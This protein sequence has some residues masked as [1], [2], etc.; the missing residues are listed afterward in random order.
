MPI[1]DQRKLPRRNNFPGVLPSA[2]L[3]KQFRNA[4]PRDILPASPAAQ[5]EQLYDGMDALRV[6]EHLAASQHIRR[7]KNLLKAKKVFKPLLVKAD[8]PPEYLCDE[9]IDEGT[10][11]KARVRL[12]CSSMVA[13]QRFWKTLDLQLIWIQLYID[14]SPQA[15]GLELFTATFDLLFNVAEPF[16]QRRLFPQVHI[17]RSLYTL[18]GKAIATLWVI[19]LVIG[20]S[21]FDLRNFCDHVTGITTDMGTEFGLYL[22]HDILIPF[23]HLLKI[24]VPR[25]CGPQEF[26]FPRALPTIGWMHS[27][28]FEIQTS[29]RVYV[30]F[31]FDICVILFVYKCC[32]FHV[33]LTKNKSMCDVNVGGLCLALTQN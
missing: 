15:R 4:A 32:S 24:H 18:R 30:Y 29:C 10:L 6:L 33:S 31:L 22:M 19:F 23:C 12:D 27:P 1:Y 20:P 14:A 26:L 28:P 16:I 7:Q 2:A 13:L 11:R 17:G 25:G 9:E 8:C 21:Y 5:H 3:L